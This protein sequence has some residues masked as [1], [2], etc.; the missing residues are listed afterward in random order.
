[1]VGGPSLRCHS[2]GNVSGF[3]MAQTIADDTPNA[4]RT[5]T[6]N[7]FGDRILHHVDHDPI[8]GLLDAGGFINN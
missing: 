7:L 5:C 8:S 1:V 2:G 4:A 6:I 3:I